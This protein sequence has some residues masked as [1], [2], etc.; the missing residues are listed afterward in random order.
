[1]KHVFSFDGSLHE[2]NR[3]ALAIERNVFNET[4]MNVCT[5]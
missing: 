5:S 1:M 2:K 4:A 3:H